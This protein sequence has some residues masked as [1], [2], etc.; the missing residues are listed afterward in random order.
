MRAF[1]TE[2]VYL[3][4]LA[5][6]PPLAARLAIAAV[7]VE[8]MRE[9]DARA[10]FQRAQAQEM[11]RELARVRGM[12][13]RPVVESLHHTRVP[14]LVPSGSDLP[15]GYDEGMIRLAHAAAF[16][17]EELE[18][19]SGIVASGINAVKATASALPKA[20]NTASTAFKTIRT[21]G[22]GKAG[23]SG[24]FDAAKGALQKAF[25][26][27]APAAG[28]APGAFQ[29]NFNKAYGR[30]QQNSAAQVSNAA[31]KASRTRSLSNVSPELKAR[32]TA[33]QQAKGLDPALA[34]QKPLVQPP[35][36]SGRQQQAA[37][38][39]A[40][41][42][43]QAA[44]MTP[45]QKAQARINRRLGNGQVQ[46][47]APSMAAPAAPPATAAPAPP[48][49]SNGIVHSPPTPATSP[50]AVNNGTVQPPS[51]PAPSTNGAVQTPQQ[52]AGGTAEPTAA[53]ENKEPGFMERAGLANGGWKGTA[54]G[55]GAMGALAFTGVKGMQTLSNALSREGSPY[56]YNQG[57][58][59]PMNGINEDGYPG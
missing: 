33:S 38:A 53:G 40:Q 55:L 4:K 21:G 22:S 7:N 56:Q 25:G 18:K 58:V 37:Q 24:V 42:Q 17:I 47:P 13:M 32:F 28:K 31:A 15:A 54:L 50:A 1:G 11:N 9:D 46:P 36:S 19:E 39:R 48:T 34:P 5:G 12:L 27:G 35:S 8:R 14:L 20:L 41:G 52:A 43:A 6:M 16:A 23:G 29:Q 10:E 2:S 3:N 51:T 49:G 57:G 30:L 26:S 59:Q 45:E 44:A